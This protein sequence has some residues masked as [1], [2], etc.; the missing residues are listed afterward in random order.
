[1]TRAQELHRRAT[2][3]NGLVGS[4]STPRTAGAE[5]TLPGVMRAG[6][7]S[8]VNLTVTLSDGFRDTC[9]TIAHL[10]NAIESQDGVRLVSTVADIEAAK[11]QGGAGITI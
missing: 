10:L 1:V 6:G 11:A 4:M 2:I 5:F 8:A 3:V 7:V 9:T